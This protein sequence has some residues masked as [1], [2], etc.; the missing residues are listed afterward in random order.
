MI[1][2]RNNDIGEHWISSTEKIANDSPHLLLK[3]Y[4]VVIRELAD[5]SARRR[6]GLC[7]FLEDLR[8]AMC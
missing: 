1:R 5:A 3:Q 6:D 8:R 7:P 4:Y 2:K